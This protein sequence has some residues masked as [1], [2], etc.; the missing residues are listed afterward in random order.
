MSWQPQVVVRDCT[1]DKVGC[2]E[3]DGRV[4]YDESSTSKVSMEA[5]S[6][7]DVDGLFYYSRYSPSVCD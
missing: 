1:C 5:V 2:Y 7:L 3:T 6:L 4:F